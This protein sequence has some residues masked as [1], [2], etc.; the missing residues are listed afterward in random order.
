M[1]KLINDLS[2][3]EY[4]DF[5][6]DIKKSGEASIDSETSGLDSFND[7]MKLLQV[8]TNN[9]IYLFNLTELSKDDFFK[10]IDTIKEY[11]KKNIFFNAKFD[12][13]FI[14]NNTGIL[15]DYIYDVMI[16]EQ[17]LGAGILVKKFP[18]YAETV[19]KYFDEVLD[20][21]VRK[22]FYEQETITEEMLIYSALDV[23]Y[24]DK[25]KEIQESSIE[26]F[27]LEAT[28]DLEMKLVPVVTM[29]ELHG[30]KLDIEKWTKIYKHF[31]VLKIKEETKLKKAIIK[32]YFELKS[33]INAIEAYSDLLIPIKTK[34]GVTPK[35]RKEFLSDLKD[36]NFM[37][38]EILED[39]NIGSPKQ[40]TVGLMGFGLF[41]DST[42]EEVL[43]PLAN[44][45]PIIKSILDY[46]GYKKSVESYGENYIER[47][48]SSTGRIHPQ[49]N[50]TGTTTGRFSSNIQQIPTRGKDKY[51]KQYRNCFI[52]EKG[53]K[54]LGV[55]YSGMEF[56]YAGTISNDKSIIDAFKLGRDLH[57]DTASLVYKT[58]YDDV[59]DDERFYGKTLNFSIIYGSTP[60]GINKGNPE[61]S[62]EEAEVLM[63][64]F[65]EVRN[66]LKSWIEKAGQEI[67]ETLSV[68]TAI[69]RIR[70]FEYKDASDF[71]NDWGPQW[72]YNKIKREGISTIIQGSCADIVKI[73][74]Y[75]IYKEN[76]FGNKL[77]MILQI[78]DELVF[79]VADE[80]AEKAKDFVVS[81][82]TGIEQSF[83]GEIPAAVNP[84]LGNYW[85]K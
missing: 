14:Y 72:Y 51:A 29:M 37:E 26:K 16:V 73:A 57:T 28:L 66:G 70:R 12:L 38:K 46:R 61:I 33:P 19:E 52:P 36:K 74:M 53:N 56:R 65:Y 67:L 75:V 9:H 58:P 68:K 8:K 1:Y 84:V 4:F 30:I 69:G 82:M 5:F 59:T 60:Y 24:L 63:D 83:L 76:P 35:P 27:K 17:I 6:I 10:V 81:V 77:K 21:E 18:S 54:I 22:G 40:L 64:T 23:D 62:I 45:Y 85:E 43:K 20:K 32:K 39:Y 2:Q 79:E 15:L 47:I 25:I 31:D 80:I 48:N 7:K 42:G 71:D 50:Q 11:S 34:N 13:S 3:T 44:E 55:D 41:L 49:F 78:H